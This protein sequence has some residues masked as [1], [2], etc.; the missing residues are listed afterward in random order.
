[1]TAKC[2]RKRSNLI[3]LR[4]YGT[5]PYAT[6]MPYATLTPMPLRGIHNVAFHALVLS[7]IQFFPDG[8]ERRDGCGAF[9]CFCSA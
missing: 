8:I 6:P 3:I 4:E 2:K 7:D 9:F 5:D 1:M